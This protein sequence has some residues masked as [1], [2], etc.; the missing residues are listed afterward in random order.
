VYEVC[1]VKLLGGEKK[2]QSHK[3]ED[4]QRPFFEEVRALLWRNGRVV[5]GRGEGEH[6]NLI[7]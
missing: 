7:W 2:I 1:Q 5:P 4:V 3:E 6:G